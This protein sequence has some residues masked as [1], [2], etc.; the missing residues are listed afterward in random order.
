MAGPHHDQ[1]AKMR[2]RLVQVKDN[3]V[4]DFSTTT[5]TTQSSTAKSSSTRKKGKANNKGKQ[6]LG[7]S[8]VAQIIVLPI[9]FFF[10][11]SYLVTDSWL[12]GYQGKYS[13]WRRWLPRKN[14]V[15]TPEEL[16]QYDGTDPNKPIYLAI[17]GEVFDVTSGGP[18]YAKGGA[19]GFFS[20][21]DA[22]R[23]YATG[24]FQT[25]LTHDLRG[26]SPGDLAAIDGWLKF[27]QNHHRYLPVGHVILPPIDPDSPIP[28]DCSQPTAAKP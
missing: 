15:F 8:A 7:K 9:V 1:G 22:S 6:K 2:T 18:F 28:E 3:V 24:C 20:G 19:Y 11:M 10:L 27:Y 14:L 25:H 16:A 5:T 21:K 26:L 4:G 23:A 12:W 17:K 13:N